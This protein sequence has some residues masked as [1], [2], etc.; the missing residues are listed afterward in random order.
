MVEFNLEK[1]CSF[2]IGTQTMTFESHLTNE[3]VKTLAEE[4]K[5][6]ILTEHADEYR[7]V[8]P[9]ILNRVCENYAYEILSKKG[10]DEI[11]N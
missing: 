10:T 4:F 3:Q 8:L 1:K 9:Y 11:V 6:I 5:H 2:N 7:D